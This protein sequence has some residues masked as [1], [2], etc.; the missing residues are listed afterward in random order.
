MLHEKFFSYGQKFGALFY[1]A[2]YFNVMILTKYL[3][4]IHVTYLKLNVSIHPSFYVSFSFQ[5]DRGTGKAVIECKVWS[6]DTTWQRAVHID[7]DRSYLMNVPDL[8]ELQLKKIEF[9]KFYMDGTYQKTIN[10]VESRLSQKEK[11]WWSKEFRIW[12]ACNGQMSAMQP[13]S[14]RFGL[15]ELRSIIAQLPSVQN[16]SEPDIEDA[17]CIALNK[18]TPVVS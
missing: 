3:A 16:R 18:L 5:L 1:I 4:L 10:I 15:K 13:T 8:N 9:P 17:A 12:G 2:M 14:E 11:E 6:Q 7:K